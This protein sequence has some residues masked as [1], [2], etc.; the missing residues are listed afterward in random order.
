MRSWAKWTAKAVVFTTGFAA[1]GGGLAGVA[2]AGT[3]TPSTAPASASNIAAVSGNHISIPV[4]VP[5]D[6]CGN[7]AAVLGF[8][9]ASCQG[10]ASVTGGGAQLTAAS[11][12]AGIG[13]PNVVV[14]PVQAAVDACGNAVGNATAHCPGGV[15]LPADGAVVAAGDGGAGGIASGNVI[16]IPVAVPVNVCG[17]A[18]A[19]LGDST[20][21]CAGGA[22]VGVEPQKARTASRPPARHLAPARHHKAKPAK[23][24]APLKPVQ[25][26]ALGTLP[27]VNDV[28]GV[29]QPL[30]REVPLLNGTA[31]H[32]VTKLPA[33]T[34]TALQASV[35][36]QPMSETSLVALSI[37]A[38][39]MGAASLKVSGRRFRVRKA[40]ADEAAAD[41]EVSA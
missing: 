32:A 8:A 4:S 10:G 28:L 25:L 13:G 1:A 18:V 6:V 11:G 12:P 37:G 23:A 5:V 17:N 35:A 21:G 3:G 27:A 36:G 19:V 40:A 20:A 26:A 9:A 15:S 38:L 14:I 16:S 33:S 39:L 7:A 29:V 24:K 34:L 31:K 22:L 2:L 30:L 41:R